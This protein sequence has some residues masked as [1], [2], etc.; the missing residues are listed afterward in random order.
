[1]TSTY[2]D[3]YIYTLLVGLRYKYILSYESICLVIKLY[4]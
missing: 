2:I 4:T 1:M 3:K